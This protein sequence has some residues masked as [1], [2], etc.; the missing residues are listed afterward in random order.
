MNPNQ[1]AKELFRIATKLDNSKLPDKNLVLSELN[2]LIYRIAVFNEP[3]RSGASY[4]AGY[5]DY[6]QLNSNAHIDPTLIYEGPM[7]IPDSGEIDEIENFDISEYRLGWEEAKAVRTAERDHGSGKPRNNKYS[8]N[9]NIQ[10]TYNDKYA[11]MSEH[12]DEPYHKEILDLKNPREL[13]DFID[14]ED[15]AND[16]RI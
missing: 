8:V 14:F 10:N 3:M 5:E 7:P 4:C 12:S 13:K 15:V 6:E 16:S 11:D 9:D 1:T 2:K